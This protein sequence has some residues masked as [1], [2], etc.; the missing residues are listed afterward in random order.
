[1]TKGNHTA[2][3]GRRGGRKSVYPNGTVWVTVPIPASHAYA[4]IERGVPLPKFMADLFEK[5]M[6]AMREKN[7]PAD[8][9]K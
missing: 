1:M 8:A 2:G 3:E 7:G 4:L 6:D 9:A 5:Y